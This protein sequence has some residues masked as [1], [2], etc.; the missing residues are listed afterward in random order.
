MFA[1]GYNFG[2][3]DTHFKDEAGVVQVR[4]RWVTKLAIERRTRSHEFRDTATSHLLFRL[5]GRTLVTRCLLRAHPAQR[6]EAD[7]RLPRAILTR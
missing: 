7:T 3:A 2:W 1:R 6:G 4:P 5:M